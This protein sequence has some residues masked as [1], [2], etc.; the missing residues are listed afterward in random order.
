VEKME[1][2]MKSS[3][4]RTKKQ[5][6]E[7]RK[8]EDSCWKKNYF[9]HVE[10]VEIMEVWQ[11]FMNLTLKCLMSTWNIARHLKQVKHDIY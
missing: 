2:D 5:K 9:I 1:R 3:I 8:I 6:K 4:K 7:G 10:V 11:F